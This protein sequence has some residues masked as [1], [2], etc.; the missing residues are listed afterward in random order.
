M[1]IRDWCCSVLG[2]IQFSDCHVKANVV[3]DDCRK[4]GMGSRNKLC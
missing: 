1:C 4:V 3:Y 2:L